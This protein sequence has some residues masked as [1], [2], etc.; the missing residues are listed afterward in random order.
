ML[1]AR[2]VRYG[3]SHRWDGKG[4]EAELALPKGEAVKTNF[5]LLKYL[6]R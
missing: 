2:F 6:S 5:G 3:D 1:A 4:R